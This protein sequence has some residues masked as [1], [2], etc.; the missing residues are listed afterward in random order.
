MRYLLF[1]IGLW[2]TNSAFADQ[3]VHLNEQKEIYHTH[4][5]WHSTPRDLSFD[6]IQN[7]FE[8]KEWD[9]LELPKDDKAFWAVLNLDN[10]TEKT[11]WTIEL[12]DVLIDSAF[13]YIQDEN[14]VWQRVNL[15]E[16]L[17][18][19]SS[20]FHLLSKQSIEAKSIAKVYISIYDDEDRSNQTLIIKSSEASKNTIDIKNTYSSVIFILISII[21]CASFGLVFFLPKQSI[22]SLFTFLLGS[23]AL[24]Y[25]DSGFLLHKIAFVPLQYIPH[26][27][28]IGSSLFI[29]FGLFYTNSF[30]QT[31]LHFPWLNKI[32][33][34]MMLF[35]VTAI[36]M[37]VL[38]IGNNSQNALYT[39][40]FGL[41][42][43]LIVI[44][45]CIIRKVPKSGFLLMC[46]GLLFLV[47]A[48]ILISTFESSLYHGV[49]FRISEFA[50]GLNTLLLPITVSS[51]R[52]GRRA[53]FDKEKSE[54]ATAPKDVAEKEF[55]KDL[56]H[57]FRHQF[58][59]FSL[60]QS[61][62]VTYISPS[63]TD[64]LGYQIS[65]IHNKNFVEVTHSVQTSEPIDSLLEK[66]FNG[67]TSEKT[68]V[69]L[70]HLK[71]HYL[72]FECTIVPVLDRYSKV[73]A[74]KGIVQDITIRK[75]SQQ[76][77]EDTLEELNASTDML[78]FSF[79]QLNKQKL[80][81]SSNNEQISASINYAKRIQRSILPTKEEFT[82]HFP[83]SFIFYQPRDIVS[84][85]FYLVRKLNDGRTLLVAA[86]C[87]GHGVPGALMSSVCIHL[88]DSVV[89]KLCLS[90]TCS[91]N[92]I[93]EDLHQSLYTTLNQETTGMNDGMDLAVC[94]IDDEREELEYAG[95]K[96][97]LIYVQNN[98]LKMVKGN[99]RSVGGELMG[100][101][102][103]YDSH[104]IDISESTVIYLFSDGFQDQFGGPQD[105][106][107]M[108]RRLREDLYKIHKLPMHQQKEV[109]EK[110]FTDW[111]GDEM[112]IDDIMLLGVRL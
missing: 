14:Q 35:A 23:V 30:L 4:P 68:E 100:S 107:Y 88:L 2:I 98:E 38:G 96:T 29:I 49:L 22:I 39:L 47:K 31:G 26:S 12:S 58:I 40:V 25:L 61:Y 11:A 16:S 79:N 20:S 70:K 43:N 46:F 56:V 27:Q 44:L 50:L 77:L 78:S 110:I 45:A 71:G 75:E 69:R 74:V 9:N 34:V 105:R 66:V 90:N 15:S 94:I 89:D 28:V 55:Y 103:N 8:N 91:A 82:S 6:L 59:F 10:Q 36:P 99:R 32:S 17:T 92:R 63:F 93:I 83:Y 48:A 21:F 60:D 42:F 7:H 109:M 106:K 86:D 85:D 37:M 102:V 53:E 33:W 64:L 111:K 72:T 65:D 19:T 24:F 54:I 112:Q 76:I 104:F 51:F 81:I 52:I 95:A 41:F 73:Y 18:I 67:D 80:L 62:K 84:G 1:I 3:I 97:P 108:A 5:T 13:I 101:T 87:T 57:N